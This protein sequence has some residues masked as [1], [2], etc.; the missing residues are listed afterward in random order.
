MRR[1]RGPRRPDGRCPA[2][3]GAA[4][5][6]SGGAVGFRPGFGHDSRS[7][8][9]TGCGRGAPLSADALGGQRPRR[10]RV[11]GAW[12][13]CGVGWSPR[14]RG[15][16]WRPCHAGARGAVGGDGGGADLASRQRAGVRPP[17]APGRTAAKA[18]S[19]TLSSGEAAC[20]T[21]PSWAGPDRGIAAG[22]LSARLARRRSNPGGEIEPDGTRAAAP[23]PFP[24]HRART[25]GARLA[26]QPGQVP[27]RQRGGG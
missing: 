18:P 13:P 6:P 3:R 23:P 7:I 21:A 22:A 26:R 8:V 14:H 11:S 27:A 1:E 17:R 9:A 20:R 4:P 10:G 25:N 24:R 5:A 2:P 19:R 15:R 12:R 16:R